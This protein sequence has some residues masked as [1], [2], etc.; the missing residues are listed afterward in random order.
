MRVH[1][2]STPNVKI[3]IEN[4]RYL[5]S[6]GTVHCF[7]TM[8]RM[9]DDEPYMR[10]IDAARAIGFTCKRYGDLKLKDSAGS[11]W[12]S[13]SSTC[14]KYYY[15]PSDYEYH[16]AATLKSGDISDE[17]AAKRIAYKKAYRQLVSFYYNCYVNLYD[18]V[19][20]Y[21]RDVWYGQIC[22]LSDRWDD[23][24]GCII[25]ATRQ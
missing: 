13:N 21:S 16:G 25:D 5:V 3:R 7:I 1:N 15:I 14:D 4:V 17:E 18:A 6:G 2:Y 11:W 8:Q 23:V 20:A 24:A 10:L 12:L 19:V 22:Q 9:T